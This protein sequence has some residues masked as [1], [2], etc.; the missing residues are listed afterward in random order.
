MNLVY[1][2][3]KLAEFKEKY[4]DL[5]H[6]ERYVEFSFS[7]PE[8]FSCSSFNHLLISFKKVAEEWK[9]SSENPANKADE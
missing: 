2:K 8:S 6:K 9:T 5:S 7:I 3:A 4:P 1:M